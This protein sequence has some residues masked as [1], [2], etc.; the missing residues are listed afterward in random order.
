MHK[1][2]IF[3][4]NL[5]KNCRFHQYFYVESGYPKHR[6]FLYGPIDHPDPLNQTMEN[7][8]EQ[9]ELKPDFPGNSSVVSRAP[10]KRMYWK[11]IFFISHPKHMLWVLKRTVSMRRF[12]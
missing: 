2:I 9:K 10:D 6:F 7:S 3:L 5:K 12:F 1:I 8:N 11:T 4:E